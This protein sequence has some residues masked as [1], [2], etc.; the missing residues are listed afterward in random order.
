MLHRWSLDQKEVTSPTSFL[1]LS[2]KET[3]CLLT[4]VTEPYT[5]DQATNF[6]L[7]E[8]LD[9][10]NNVIT[11]RIMKPASANQSSILSPEDNN[12][13]TMYVSNV[14][15]HDPPADIV[16]T[17][18][19]KAVR[20]ALNKEHSETIEAITL[21]PK[22]HMIEAAPPKR[23]E[24]LNALL[25]PTTAAKKDQDREKERHLFTN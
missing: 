9:L 12:D 17:D 23:G 10:L 13:N 25:R 7:R 2:P 21:P 14:Q 11:H 4:N 6:L 16:L 8:Y 22:R 18:F 3:L 24:P 19:G 20:M 1:T 15:F 5:K